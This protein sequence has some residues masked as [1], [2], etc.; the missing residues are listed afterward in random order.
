[1][2]L[3]PKEDQE[4]SFSQK[5]L[6]TDSPPRN[7]FTKMDPSCSAASHKY[8]SFDGSCNN[9]LLPSRGKSGTNYRRFLRPEYEDGNSTMRGGGSQEGRLPSPRRVSSF[10]QAVGPGAHGGSPSPSLSMLVSAWTQLIAEDMS[11]TPDSQSGGP[12]CLDQMK[13]PP[14]A[15]PEDDCQPI[16]VS[17]DP[18]FRYVNKTCLP[19]VRSQASQLTCSTGHR[20]QT[21]AATHY[22]DAS[23][24][25]G[26]SNVEAQERRTFRGGEVLVG[27]RQVEELTKSRGN[28]SILVTPAL[29]AMHQLWLR[30]H[31]NLARQ[32]SVLNPHW[33][34]DTLFQEARRLV[35]A[36]IQHVTYGEYLPL[37]LGQY[38]QELQLYPMN[39]GYYGSYSPEIDATVA[40]AFG[41]AAFRFVHSMITES[42]KVGPISYMNLIEYF[43]RGR[44]SEERASSSFLKGLT[45]SPAD[46]VDHYFTP[47][48]HNSFGA[49][50]GHP[51]GSDLYALDVQRGRDHGLQGYT[52]WRR[53]C[54]LP[55]VTDFSQLS[56]VMPRRLALVF[57]LLYRKV[58]DIDLYP[59]GLAEYRLPRGLV[60]PTFAC[61]IGGQFLYTRGG[62]RFWYESDV[63]VLPFDQAQLTSFVA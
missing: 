19:F 44:S 17:D 54:G 60:G 6:C 28:S 1:M 61:V 22:L 11:L 14:P 57:Q 12:C 13:P 53:A 51:V 55:A 20:E 32:L 42:F 24:I 41:A 21:N 26:S 10:L 23:G 9:L 3:T 4:K 56:Q 40:N 16:D 2:L 18:L 8:R 47:T 59:A 48:L 7:C 37:V 5:S 63:L 25:Y 39:S 36:M 58:E 50:P 35:V 46:P 29:G 49:S 34:D 27:K 31:N 38:A 45:E 30:I 62:D 33:E 43:T 52:S 15:S